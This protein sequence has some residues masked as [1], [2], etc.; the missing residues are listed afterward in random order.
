MKS[1]WNA[2]GPLPRCSDA[3][4]AG[5]LG[6]EEVR[7][8]ADPHGL[9]GSDEAALQQAGALAHVVQQRS[10]DRV[11]HAEAQ[12]G[13]EVVEAELAVGRRLFEPRGDRV[14][15]GI[16][17]HRLAGELEHPA[18]HVRVDERLQLHPTE[19]VEVFD[20][21]GGDGTARSCGDVAHAKIPGPV[22]NA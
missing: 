1:W 16:V 22:R 8:V 10:E 17:T 11:R 4:G 21:V 2:V 6:G 12:V 15:V 18:D 5:Q 19:L 7:V 9:A 20:L 13:V 3:R 14:A